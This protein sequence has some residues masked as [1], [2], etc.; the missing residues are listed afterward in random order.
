MGQRRREQ[1]EAGEWQSALTTK[2]R[3]PWERLVTRG[4]I[5]RA[6]PLGE[7]EAERR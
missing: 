5:G 4:G 7:A 1:M 2:G 3:Q 6:P